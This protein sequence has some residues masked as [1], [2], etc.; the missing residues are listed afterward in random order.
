M[1]ILHRRGTKQ[2]NS[3]LTYIMESVDWYFMGHFVQ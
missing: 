2:V 1:I 3:L